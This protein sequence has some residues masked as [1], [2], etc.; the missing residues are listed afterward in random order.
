VIVFAQQLGMSP[1]RVCVAEPEWKPYRFAGIDGAA[2]MA[3]LWS[4][5]PRRGRLEFLLDDV[6]FKQ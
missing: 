6:R 3:I 2:L 5:G 4:G 1:I